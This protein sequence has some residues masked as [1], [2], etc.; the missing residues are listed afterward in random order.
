MSACHLKKNVEVLHSMLFAF[1]SFLDQFRGRE[2]LEKKIRA[3]NGTS[4]RAHH[5]SHLTLRRLSVTDKGT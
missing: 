5:L 2:R 4:S 3:K 1:L